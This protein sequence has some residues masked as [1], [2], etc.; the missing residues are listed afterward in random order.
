MW[1]LA[2]WLWRDGRRH[3]VLVQPETVAGWRPVRSVRP[4]RPRLTAETQALIA[5]LGRENPAWGSER[6][7]GERRKLGSGVSQ[8]SLPRHQGRGPAR[9]PSQSWRAFLA[10][11][12]GQLLAAEQR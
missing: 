9:P 1:I 4:V 8:C 2:R 6:I 12:V 5:W 7:R 3:L 11:Q 10:H